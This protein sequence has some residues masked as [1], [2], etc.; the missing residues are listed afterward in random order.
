MSSVRA[1][2]RRLSGSLPGWWT[3]AVEGGLESLSHACTNQTSA[4][5]DPVGKAYDRGRPQWST[6]NHG[7]P[8]HL[9]RLLIES[10]VVTCLR[11][12]VRCSDAAT[13]V[14]QSPT[15]GDPAQSG[16]GLY[17]ASDARL[18]SLQHGADR[19]PASVTYACTNSSSRDPIDAGQTLRSC[20]AG[21]SSPPGLNDHPPSR[22]THS[23]P[24]T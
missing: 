9:R 22:A 16:C 13:P 14:G 11:D 5:S 18:R 6:D 7:C 2:A 1:T 20:I 15:L 8:G 10:R 19:S 12:G 3:L 17:L 4:S 23:A 24:S 21:S